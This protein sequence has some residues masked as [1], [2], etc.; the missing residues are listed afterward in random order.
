MRNNSPD[1]GWFFCVAVTSL[2]GFFS[3]CN[4]GE[5][6][7][8]RQAVQQNQAHYTVDNEGKTTFVWGAKE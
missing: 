1:L 3:G 6:R 4:T 8:Q 5:Q 7:I 2:L